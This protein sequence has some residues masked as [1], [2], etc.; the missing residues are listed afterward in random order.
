MGH[1]NAVPRSRI[2]SGV[3]KNWFQGTLKKLDRQEYNQLLVD[4]TN[5][6]AMVD[7][8]PTEHLPS[9]PSDGRYAEICKA[10]FLPETF[11]AIVS[12]SRN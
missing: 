9:T 1:H 3:V 6:G 5:G 7:E 4:G 11:F 12:D 8:D 2:C 10:T